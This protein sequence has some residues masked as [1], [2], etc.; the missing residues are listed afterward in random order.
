MVRKRNL[1]VE[2]EPT[3]KVAIAD[4]PE[5]PKKEQVLGYLVTGE[6]KQ[7]NE[8]SSLSQDS[9]TSTGEIISPNGIRLWGMW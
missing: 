6:G 3:A 4:R 2:H 8:H 5:E 1:L 7:N 9:V